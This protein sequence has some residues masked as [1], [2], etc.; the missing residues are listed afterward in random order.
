MDVL[1]GLFLCLGT[2][3]TLVASLGV[4][5]LP[6]LYTRMH[7]ATKAG[8]VGVSCLLLAVAFSLPE[9]TVISRVI[10]T[11]LFI[12]LTAPVASHL[13]GRAMREVRYKIWRND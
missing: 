10:G 7:A 5:R 12:V 4:L 2:L 8:T 1:I 6:D 9:V 13:L 11:M 3:L